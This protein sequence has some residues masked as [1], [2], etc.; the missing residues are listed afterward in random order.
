MERVSLCWQETYGRPFTEEDAKAVFD[1]FLPRQLQCVKAYCKLM[2]HLM[3][4]VEFLKN[5]DIPIG[6][7]TGYN[8]EIMEIVKKEAI[9]FQISRRGLTPVYGVLAW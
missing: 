3:T 9:R 6:S 7:T 2:P 8:S 1:S 4:A 5:R